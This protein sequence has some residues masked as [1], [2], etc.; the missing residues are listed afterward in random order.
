MCGI[1]VVGN[2]MKL[3]TFFMCHPVTLQD[4]YTD[5]TINGA[6]YRLAFAIYASLSYINYTDMFSSSQ[7]E[8]VHCQDAEPSLSNYLCTPAKCTRQ[9]SINSDFIKLSSNV[10]IFEIILA[11]SVPVFTITIMFSGPNNAHSASTDS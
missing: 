7:F 10:L 5:C 9:I 1:H 4:L 2:K 11:A 8:A 3:S 6:K